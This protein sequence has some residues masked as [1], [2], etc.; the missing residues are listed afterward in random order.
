MLSQSSIRVLQ[1]KSMLCAEPRFDR[2]PHVG[3]PIYCFPTLRSGA[4]PF[5]PGLLLNVWSLALCW[6]VLLLT[7]T[8]S[9]RGPL[10][11]TLGLLPFDL[12]PRHVV[13]LLCC[14]LSG[15]YIYCASTTAGHW[16]SK[17]LSPLFRLW[18]MR[19]S[20]CRAF[21][22]VVLHFISHS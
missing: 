6:F 1:H 13:G 8:S 21:T 20:N 3:E 4:T 5:I 22:H 2:T 10:P 18:Y 17:I 7:L 14:P 16:C 19:N 12:L 9:P 11:F 15:S